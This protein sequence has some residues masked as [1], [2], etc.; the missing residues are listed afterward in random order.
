MANRGVTTPAAVESEARTD[1]VSSVSSIDSH[2]ELIE[3]GW[4]IMWAGRMSLPRESI[5]REG[6]F[7]LS[8]R[9][10]AF[11]AGALS[12]VAGTMKLIFGS[13]LHG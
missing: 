6:M 9:F 5:E 13:P 1:R 4:P 10:P 11:R 7:L 3:S 8:D 2:G 12:L